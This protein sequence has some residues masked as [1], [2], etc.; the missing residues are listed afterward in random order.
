MAIVIDNISKSF[1][2]NKVLDRI[3]LDLPEKGV[4]CFVGKSGSGKTT[5][6]NIIAN[7]IPQD[8]GKIRGLENKKIAYVFQED[9]LVPYLSAKENVKLVL[10]FD[11]D[12]KE[13]ISLFWLNKLLL[14]D[15][16]NKRPCEL[17]GG[18]RRRVSIAR[19][20]AYDA[21]ILLLD[22]PF[23]GLDNNTKGLVL[24]IIKKESKKYLILLITHNYD[25]AELLSDLIYTIT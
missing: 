14:G 12:E 11:E 22:E 9:R 25:E 15:F 7:I 3:S 5:L 21:D 1:G 19:A 4:V 18:M 2:S 17:S 24:D 10:D 13:K 8:S 6:F 20:L 23:N 16:S